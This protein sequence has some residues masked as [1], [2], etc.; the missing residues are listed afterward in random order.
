MGVKLR[1]VPFLFCPVCK[2]NGF[3]IRCEN[4]QPSLF[5]ENKYK[6]LKLEPLPLQTKVAV[7]DQFDNIWWIKDEHR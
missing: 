6:Y 7:V 5:G 3:D 2:N 4:C 1:E